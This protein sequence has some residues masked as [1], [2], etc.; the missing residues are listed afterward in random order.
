VEVE[1]PDDDDERGPKRLDSPGHRHGRTESP[2]FSS[3]A[4]TAIST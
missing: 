1:Q 4:A 2:L 3:Q